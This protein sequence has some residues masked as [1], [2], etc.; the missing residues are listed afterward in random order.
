MA[1]NGFRSHR[2]GSVWL[3]R[4]QFLEFRHSYYCHAGAATCR[5]V[6]NSHSCKCQ[7]RLP[8]F[9]KQYPQCQDPVRVREYFILIKF[10]A[11]IHYSESPPT[12]ILSVNRTN[13]KPGL[14]EVRVSRSNGNFW[15]G[16]TCGPH[17]LQ[18]RFIVES[19][20]L[21]FNIHGLSES[22]AHVLG[23]VECGS[24]QEILRPCNYTPLVNLLIL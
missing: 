19:E 3:T 9:L 8:S 6:S 17:N 20:L 11:L 10:K 1:G 4:T 23:T 24:A 7:G 12:L 22:A 2:V 18:I 13:G 14:Q 15:V 16:H 21:G 5:T